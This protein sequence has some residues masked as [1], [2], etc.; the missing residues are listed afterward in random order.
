MPF[1]PR[2]KQGIAAEPNFGV[3]H[4]VGP[5][6]TTFSPNAGGLVLAGFAPAVQMSISPAK[7]SLLLTGVAPSIRTSIGPG[8]RA[9][10]LT[11]KTPAIS[12]SVSPAK[13][14]LSLTGKTPAVAK[15]VSPAVGFL[16]FNKFA[17]TVSF[18]MVIVV[19]VAHGTLT[20]NAPDVERIVHLPGF[21]TRIG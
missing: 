21:F 19:P 15:S 6:T 11:G 2:T 10:S 18:A 1:V 7:A 8:V 17:P 16:V 20:G 14:S 12:K 3:L 13:A 4:F 9:L 5:Q